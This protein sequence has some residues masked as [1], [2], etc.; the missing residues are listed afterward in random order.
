MLGIG[1][2][3]RDCSEKKKEEWMI[4][5]AKSGSV[6][7]EECRCKITWVIWITGFVEKKGSNLIAHTVL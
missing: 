3:K 6:Y 1:V 4:Y 7:W 2:K 5:V